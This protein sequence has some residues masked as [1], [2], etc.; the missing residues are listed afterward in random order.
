VKL[1]STLGLSLA[2]IGSLA[3]AANAATF[4]CTP[5]KVAVLNNRM[6]AECSAAGTDGASTIYYWSVPT[7]DTAFAN[8]FLSVVSSA[9]ISGRQVE[10]VFN[11][12]DTSGSTFGCDGSNCRRLQYFVLR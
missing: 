5:T 10:M 7:S 3:A 11:P 4:V 12:G 1:L 2:M 9:I 8:R 6:H